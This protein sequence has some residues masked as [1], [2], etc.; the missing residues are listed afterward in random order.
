MPDD[1]ELNFTLDTDWKKQQKRKQKK[2]KQKKSTISVNEKKK[3]IK[4]KQK[5]L[6]KFKINFIQRDLLFGLLGMSLEEDEFASWLDLPEKS[7][8]KNVEKLI[9]YELVENIATMRRK[10]KRGDKRIHIYWQLTEKG[11]K[12]TLLLLDWFNVQQKE[13]APDLDKPIF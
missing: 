10:R 5:N 9:K 8:I 6:G 1:K 12:F 11:E 3:N 2:E 7:L 13:P 4:F